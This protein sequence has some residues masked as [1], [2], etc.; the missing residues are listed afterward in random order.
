MDDDVYSPEGV[1]ISG[2]STR[3]EPEKPEWEKEWERKYLKPKASVPTAQELK[4]FDQ[5]TALFEAEQRAAAEKAKASEVGGGSGSNVG[6]GPQAIVEEAVDPYLEKYMS[7]LQKREAASEKQKDIDVYMSLMQAGLG[8]MGGSS[9]YAL[10]NIGAG[11]SQGLSAYAAAQKQ[12]AAEEAATLSGY[13]KLYTAKQAAEL[14]RELTASG[15]EERMARFDEQQD[16]RIG[17]ELETIRKNITNEVL[18]RR[19]LGIEALTD[20]ATAPKIRA[21]VDA[22]LI[23]HGTYPRLYKQYNKEPF[24]ATPT[25]LALNTPEFYQN[26][27]NTAPKTKE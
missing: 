5:A 13:G 12:R 4:D 23:K 11:G 20:P 27:Y 15:R 22:E 9:P 19:K 7:M 1:L 16:L 8:M 10:Q 18:A 6:A 26:K 21:E 24:T 3:M 14:K 25:T 17:R 2:G